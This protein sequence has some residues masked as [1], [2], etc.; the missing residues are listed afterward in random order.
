L[1]L[2]SIHH[3]MPSVLPL[4]FRPQQRHE[5][6]PALTIRDLVCS[7]SA[8][9]WFCRTVTTVTRFRRLWDSRNLRSATLKKHI[10]VRRSSDAEESDFE[11]GPIRIRK[12]WNW[13]FEHK[14]NH[15]PPDSLWS[16]FD[17]STED[18]VVFGKSNLWNEKLAKWPLRAPVQHRQN[19]QLI[20]TECI[21]AA[22]KS[23]RADSV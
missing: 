3:S 14:S 1:R 15:H 20:Q 19:R 8:I 13:V 4:L 12:E 22:F 6:P 18:N 7:A 11:N 16:V 10:L 17:Q 21:R 9:L 2:W 23:V 5:D